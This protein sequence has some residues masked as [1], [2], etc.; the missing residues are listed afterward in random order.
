VGMPVL[1]FKADGTRPFRIDPATKKVVAAVP[2]P[3]SAQYSRWV[4]NFDDN[5]PLLRLP[6]LKDT[7]A[8]PDGLTVHY[9]DPAGK[10]NNAQIF[11][12]QLTQTADPAREYYKPFNANK[13]IL[14]SAGWDRIYGTKD[15]ITNFD[16]K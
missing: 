6:W 11:Y 13:Y 9:K 1:Y 16:V 7:A 3:T 8:N 2:G 5:L 10:S 15:D 4:Y 14:I 12:E